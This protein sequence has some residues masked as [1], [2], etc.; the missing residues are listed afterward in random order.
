[1]LVFDICNRRSFEAIPRWLTYVRQVRPM[2]LAQQIKEY[3]GF[4]PE[5]EIT[6]LPRL[7]REDCSLVVLELMHI[8]VK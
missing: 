8:V 2:I 7:S 5:S 3:L 1:M 4:K 6:I